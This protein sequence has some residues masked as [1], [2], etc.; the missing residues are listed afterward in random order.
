MDLLYLAILP[1][2]I[3]ALNIIAYWKTIFF[4]Y[5][6]DDIPTFHK[7]PKA[8]NKAHRLYQWIIGEF[9]WKPK[10]DHIL[11]LSIHTSICL[12]IYLAFGSSWFSFVAACL[13]AVNPVNNQGA[14]WISGRGYTI[15]TLLILTSMALPIISPLL[16]PACSYFTIGFLSPLVVIGSNQWFIVAVI[17]IAWAIN[18][19]K[20]S[21]AVKY[22]SQ[23][24]TVEEDRIIRPRKLILGIKTMGFYLALCIIPFKITFYHSFLQ[25]CAGNENMRKK[26][27]TLCKFFW[28]G[29]FAIL[30]WGT[31]WYYFGWDMVTY[32]M[33]W[34]FIGIA[35]FCNIRRVQQEISERYAYLP[36]VGV[37]VALSAIIYQYPV[38]ITAFFIMYLTKLW[39]SMYMYADDYYLVERSVCEDSQA[40]YAWHVRALK[41]WSASSYREASILWV[42]A[43]MINPKEF[44]LLFNL[45]MV[46]KLL[47]NHK[48]SRHYIE[49]ARANIIKGQEKEVKPLFK[50]YDKGQVTLVN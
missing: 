7:P 6:S 12:M 31:Y 34:F 33:L 2:V 15:P 23:T 50:A 8:K 28:I 26:A 39:S 46:L 13:Y 38:A 3:I 29:L 43:Y 17:P 5:V 21:K 22:K 25:S 40:W 41:R 37:M 4:K 30:A 16:I 19:R 48:E 9:K 18:Y 44:K 42:M 32:G 45:A 49:L 27:Y 36:N 1:M 14:I 24:E 20:F 47:G 10:N 11:T 35:P